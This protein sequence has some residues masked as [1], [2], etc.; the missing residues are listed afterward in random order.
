MDGVLAA[1]DFGVDN[2]I[3]LWFLEDYAARRW[4]CRHQVVMPCNPETRRLLMPQEPLRSLPLAAAADSEG[5][6]ML[7]NIKCLAVYNVRN[8]TVRTVDSVATA[9][10]NVVVSRHIFKESLVPHPHF[11]ERSPA[12]MQFNY[13][14]R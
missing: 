8:K 9:K 10:D 5:N 3:N 12:E 2:H 4:E 7:G 1:A 6:I 11:H 13:S 14:W